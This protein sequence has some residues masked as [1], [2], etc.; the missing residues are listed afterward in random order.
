MQLKPNTFRIDSADWVPS[1]NHDLRP[2]G[3]EPEV[4]IVHCI[5]LPPGEYGG[6]EVK[7][8]FQNKLSADEHPYFQSMA[9]VS[10]THLTLPTKA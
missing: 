4:I 5:S 7:R 10:Y 2:D 6:G 3:S 8:F 1:P 9:P